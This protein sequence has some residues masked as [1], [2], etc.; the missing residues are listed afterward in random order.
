M[1]EKDKLDG[2]YLYLTF[3][4]PRSYSDFGKWTAVVVYKENGKVRNAADDT[5]YYDFEV[6]AAIY[7]KDDIERYQDETAARKSEPATL[8]RVG[9]NNY[10]TV[11][12]QDCV[13]YLPVLKRVGKSLQQQY[14]TYG[15]ACTFAD[16]LARVAVA[17][18]AKGFLRQGENLRNGAWGYDEFEH[19]DMD[20]LSM[21]WFVDYSHHEYIKELFGEQK[22]A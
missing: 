5:E 22:V 19:K 21:R 16:F 2:P 4:S 12:L 11:E 13:R 6:T 3:C 15:S 20:T 14:E 7:G 9:F 10:G 17:I 8:Y 18:K 1:K